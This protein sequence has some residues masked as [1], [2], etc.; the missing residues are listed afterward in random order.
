[1]AVQKSRLRSAPH[2]NDQGGYR[3][4]DPWRNVIVCGEHF[5]LTIST[6]QRKVLQPFEWTFTRSDLDRLLERPDDTRHPATL[7]A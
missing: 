4:I 3:L 7:A 1:L 5:D 6:V 2:L